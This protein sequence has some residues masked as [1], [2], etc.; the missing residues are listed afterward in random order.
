VNQNSNIEIRNPKQIRMTKI[1][2]S[3]WYDLEDRTLRFAQEIRAFVKKLPKGMT[4]IEDSRQLVDASVQSGQI[5]LRRMRQ[6]AKRI[7]LCVSR[8]VVRRPRKADIG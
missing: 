5:I 3:K 7:F 4:N 6:L 1:Q 2:N 8:Y